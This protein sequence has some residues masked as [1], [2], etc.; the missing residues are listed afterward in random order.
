MM[1]SAGGERG[2]EAQVM[3][4]EWSKTRE[5]GNKLT[6]L[7]EDRC[8]GGTGTWE[9]ERSKRQTRKDVKQIR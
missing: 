8:G 4:N 1:C 9:G 2:G 6:R 3:G 5:Q 7:M